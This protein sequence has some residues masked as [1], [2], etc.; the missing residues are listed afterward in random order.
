MRMQYDLVILA[1]DFPDI[2]LMVEV[3]VGPL[4][5]KKREQESLR[6]AH[7]MWEANC[8]YGLLVSTSKTY[9]LKDTFETSDADSIRIS[10]TLATKLV[11]GELPPRPSELE[12]LLLVKRWL[13]RLVVSYDEVLGDDPLLAQVFFPDIV[14][15]VAGGRIE[16]GVAV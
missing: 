16:T 1:R 2:V 13:E 3:K 6:L 8:H 5:N 11:F 10:H 15:A 4:S 14:G 9:V 12:L 7:A